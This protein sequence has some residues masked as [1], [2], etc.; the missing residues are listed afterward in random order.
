MA[1]S[2]QFN[3]EGDMHTCAACSVFD[4]MPSIT[5]EWRWSHGINIIR[6]HERC[7]ERRLAGAKKKAAKDAKAKAHEFSVMIQEMSQRAKGE[8]P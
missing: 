6:I 4:N 5:L 1:F 8:K 7:L 3:P 2:I